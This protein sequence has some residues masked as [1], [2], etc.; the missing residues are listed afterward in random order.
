MDQ[1]TSLMNARATW[2]VASVFGVLASIGGMTH[3]VGEIR[4]GNVAPENF[5]FP[6]WAD[7]PIATE[8]GG[9]PAISVVPNFLVTGILAL[10]V[11]G[12]ML[13][14]AAAFVQRK[15]G[16]LV[17]MLLAIVLLLVGGGIGSPVIAFLAGVAGTRI[18]AP[19]RWW[20]AHV[21]TSLQRALAW[22][23]PWVFALALVNGL[24]LFVGAVLLVYS[25]SLNNSDL[26]L[27][28]FYFAVV[29]V[30]LSII[31]AVAHDVQPRE[32]QLVA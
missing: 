24:F 7:G 12:A 5:F 13:V 18:H 21:T 29:S 23:W 17:L 19:H 9:D 22:L 1:V 20:R 3:G 4:Q 6:S 10:I 26:F 15:H 31:A 30:A 28:S 27:N 8:M 14:W 11:S 2:L 32:E 25:I 16:G